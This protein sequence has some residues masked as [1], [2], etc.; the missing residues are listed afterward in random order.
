MKIR[1]MRSDDVRTGWRGV[2]DEVMTGSTVTVERYNKPVA[3]VIPYEAYLAV[4]RELEDFFDLAL[5][6]AAYAEYKQDPSTAMPL[7]EAIAL[8]RAGDANGNEDAREDAN[9]DIHEN[10]SGDNGGNHG[11][12]NE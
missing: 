8:W 12:S 6:E 2:M 5:A 7:E 3:A 1:V 11:E 9:G 10:N 4:Q